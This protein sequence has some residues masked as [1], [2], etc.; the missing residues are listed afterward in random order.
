[1]KFLVILLVAF[2]FG[3]GAY[4]QEHEQDAPEKPEMTLVGQESGKTLHVEDKK[5]KTRNIQ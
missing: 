1:M 2:G 4:A 3:M 5:R